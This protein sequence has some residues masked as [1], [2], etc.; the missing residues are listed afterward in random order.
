[1]L[2]VQSIYKKIN[3]LAPREK[4]ILNLTALVVF[5]MI[6]D[7]LVISPISSQ[8]EDL[9]T[10]LQQEETT[11]KKNLRILAQK[12]KIVAESGR[13]ESYLRFP[14]SPEEEVTAMLK[15]LEDLANKNSVYLVLSLIHI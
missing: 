7:R 2:D 9:N 13:F 5:L 14:L 11:I 1:M 15:E 3:Q 4:L 12:D 6:L 8:I 10:Q